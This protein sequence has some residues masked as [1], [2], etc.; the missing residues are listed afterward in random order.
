MNLK[1]SAKAFGC[2]LSASMLLTSGCNQTLREASQDKSQTIES[3]LERLNQA[4][5]ARLS[6]EEYESVDGMRTS[7]RFPDI[8]LI[9]HRG[10]DLKFY[11][12]L[13]EDRCVCIVYFYTRC[14]GSCPITTQV[15]KKLQKD[16]A[17]E[18]GDNLLFVSLTLEPEVDSPQEL[19]SYMKLHGIED[20]PS[21][22]EWIYATGDFE[23]LDGLRK[24]LGIYDLDPVIDADKT[25]HAAILTFGNDRL[26]RW[27]ALPVGM[28]YEQLKTAMIRIMG[29]S[30]RQRFSSVVQYREEMMNKYRDS[31]AKN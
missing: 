3:D 29:N 24:T 18:F 9:D 12:D 27:A 2:I 22:P 17:E 10:R 25:E 1:P 6:T 7:D 30:P 15:V 28:D 26:N 16:L 21:L 23:E 11:T 19:Q 20:N 14:V 31:I 4:R 5:V 8:Q 13:V